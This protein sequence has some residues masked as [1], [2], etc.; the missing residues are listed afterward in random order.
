MNSGN[1]QIL[2]SQPQ[3]W[4]RKNPALPAYLFKAQVEENLSCL[5]KQI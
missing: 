5:Q 4:L 1:D 2:D 3:R